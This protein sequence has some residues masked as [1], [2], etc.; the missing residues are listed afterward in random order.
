MPDQVN[1]LNSDLN[2]KSIQGKKELML[3]KNHITG[4]IMQ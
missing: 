3:P 4:D 1:R 2:S